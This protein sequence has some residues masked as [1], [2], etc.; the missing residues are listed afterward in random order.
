MMSIRRSTSLLQ[1]V[2][3][4]FDQLKS[5]KMLCFRWTNKDNLQMVSYNYLVYNII[6][7]DVAASMDPPPQF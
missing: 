7:L 2:F 1:H 6:I 4:Y 5:Y 3:A